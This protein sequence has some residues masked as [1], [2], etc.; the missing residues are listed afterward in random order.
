MPIGFVPG[1]LSM[2]SAG[3]SSVAFP[4][5]RVP[6]HRAVLDDVHGLLPAAAR[7]IAELQRCDLDAVGRA[8]EFGRRALADLPAGAGAGDEKGQAGVDPCRRAELAAGR[9]ESGPLRK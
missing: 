4:D 5:L 7:A 8:A 9:G 3:G 1:T 6:G 2:G